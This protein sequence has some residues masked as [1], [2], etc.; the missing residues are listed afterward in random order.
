MAKSNCTPGCGELHVHC[1]NCGAVVAAGE[2][3]RCT[4]LCGRVPRCSECALEHYD[5]HHSD[6]PRGKW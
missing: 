3:N 2:Q 1:D 4:W 6:R 5:T